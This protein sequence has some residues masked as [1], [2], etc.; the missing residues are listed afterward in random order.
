[1]PAFSARITK[2]VGHIIGSHR[3]PSGRHT[4]FQIGDGACQ[5]TLAPPQSSHLASGWSWLIGP[6]SRCTECR[7]CVSGEFIAFLSR[8]R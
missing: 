6:T 4:L 5:T 3:Y 7:D 2:H 1:M 8:H